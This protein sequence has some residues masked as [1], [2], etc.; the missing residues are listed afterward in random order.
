MMGQRKAIDAISRYV[1][2]NNIRIGDKL[3]SIREIANDTGL[4]MGT[5]ARAIKSLS[6]EGIVISRNRSGTVLAKQLGNDSAE[7]VQRIIMLNCISNN[8]TAGFVTDEIIAGVRREIKSLLPKVEFLTVW[9]TPEDDEESLE[10]IIHYHYVLRGRPKNVVFILCNA[11]RWIKKRFQDLKIPA[12][13]QGGN[14]EGI[15]LPNI[16]V[17]VE[18][19][20]EEIIRALDKA[21]GYPAAFLVDVELIIG[22]QNEIIEYFAEAAKNRGKDITLFRMNN[23]LE[24]FRSQLMQILR[25]EN[26]PK[27]LIA[28]GDES[29]IRAARVC[30]ELGLLDKVGIISMQS[31]SFGEQ[32]MP[33]LTGLCRDFN[34]IAA[35]IVEFSERICNGE[36]LYGESRE[37]EAILVFR[38]SFKNPYI[39]EEL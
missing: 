10:D 32:F 12:I 34:K 17:D 27:T 19:A 25:S 11:P 1:R 6:E 5:V 35:D 14:E 33:S 26:P 8:N 15:Y 3:P 28:R 16:T 29:A 38:E 24:L 39:V 30:F 21:D 18:G 9:F 2:L 13:V 31:S 37:Y 20:A 4:A 23:A 7:T 36:D 22:Y